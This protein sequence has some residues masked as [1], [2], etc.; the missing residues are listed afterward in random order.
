METGLQIALWLGVVS[1][2]VVLNHCSRYDKVITWAMGLVVSG[3]V[4]AATIVL[5]VPIFYLSQPRSFQ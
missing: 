4:E 2:G 3:D 1:W 5:V